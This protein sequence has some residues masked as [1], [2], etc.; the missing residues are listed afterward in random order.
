M[1]RVN[2]LTDLS[3]S[4]LI[5]LSQ[6]RGVEE[7]RA[8]KRDGVRERGTSRRGRQ[9]GGEG[10]NREL[11]G[12]P[13]VPEDTRSSAPAHIHLY[14][15]FDYLPESEIAASHIYEPLYMCVCVCVDVVLKNYVFK[16]NIKNSVRET[17]RFPRC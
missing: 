13:D 14:A 12:C 9:T 3:R 6:R 11:E 2:P 17:L 4:Y 7:T 1:G 16:E 8:R 10:A 15:L 5:C